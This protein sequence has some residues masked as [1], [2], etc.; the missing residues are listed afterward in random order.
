MSKLSLFTF[1]VCI[2]HTYNEICIM[3]RKILCQLLYDTPDLI[4]TILFI[5]RQGPFFFMYIFRKL[6]DGKY[7]Q[8]FVGV[9]LNAHADVRAGVEGSFEFTLSWSL[10]CFCKLCGT[11]WRHCIMHVWQVWEQCNNVP[12]SR[13]SCHLLQFGVSEQCI[14]NFDGWCTL[15]PWLSGFPEL[16]LFACVKRFLF[17]CDCIQVGLLW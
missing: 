2:Y 11:P 1:I 14:S 16:E 10:R 13:Y 12:S 7:I 3:H 8:I 9:L 17:F 4:C 5:C 6:L 15:S